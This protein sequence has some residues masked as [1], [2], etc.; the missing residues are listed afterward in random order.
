[1]A[2]RYLSE[3]HLRKL[4]D[5]LEFLDVLKQHVEKLGPADQRYKD[6]LVHEYDIPYSKLGKSSLDL[7]SEDID[8]E[9]QTLRFEIGALSSY[10][11]GE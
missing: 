5:R 4:R 2:N 7:W 3:E 10:L 1:M 9:Q 8:R 6:A 11:L